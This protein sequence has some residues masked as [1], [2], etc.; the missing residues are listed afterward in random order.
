MICSS[1]S[2]GV[3]YCSTA[4]LDGEITLKPKQ[5]L[6]MIQE[7][8]MSNEQNIFLHKMNLKVKC[9]L[10]EKTIYQFDARGKFMYA[11][12]PL[13]SSKISFNMQ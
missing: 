8:F 7:N 1:E 13:S 3:A 5:S 2:N 11:N 10:P 9:P 4:T 6:N 12:N